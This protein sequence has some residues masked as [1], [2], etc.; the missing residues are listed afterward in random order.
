[1]SNSKQQIDGQSS[2]VSS[3]SAENKHPVVVVALTDFST[4]QS[5]SDG[6]TLDQQHKPEAQVPAC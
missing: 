1:M 4:D 3:L 2:A 6:D 5:G